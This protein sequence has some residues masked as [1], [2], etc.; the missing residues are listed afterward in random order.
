[1]DFSQKII[2]LANTYKDIDEFVS[3]IEEIFT[4][5]SPQERG[6]MFFE[7]GMI[8]TESNCLC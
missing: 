1:M 7:A 4:E 8:L 2:Q 5:T 6:N 3:K